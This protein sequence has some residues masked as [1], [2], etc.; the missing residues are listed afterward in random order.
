MPDIFVTLNQY[1]TFYPLVAF[2]ALL[3]AGLNVPISEDLIIITGALLCHEEPSLLPSCLA[4]LYAGTIISDFMSYW[5]GV[6]VKKGAVKIRFAARAFSPKNIDKMRYYLNRYGIFT[7]IVCRFIPFGVRNTLFMTS[8]I[9]GLRIRM[10]ALYDITAAAISVN[11]LF[12]LVYRFGEDIKKPVKIAGII[13]FA[14][15][16]SGLTALLF[17]CI[18]RKYRAWRSKPKGHA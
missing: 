6:Q 11:T 15:L 10:F 5:L 8:G 17:R 1:L 2:I 14:L 3:L 13:L 16:V 18:S 4:A 12:F 9:L 7:F